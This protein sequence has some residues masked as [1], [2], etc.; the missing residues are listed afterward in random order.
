MQRTKYSFLKRKLQK[1]ELRF[2]MRIQA[3]NFWIVTIY[4]VYEEGDMG[5][6]YGFIFRYHGIAY[7]GMNTDYTGQGFDQIEYCINLLKTDPFSRRILMTSFN[8]SQAQQGVL[9]PCHSIV[10]QFYVE[11]GHRLSCTMYQRSADI[12]C[13]TPFNVAS[14]SLLVYMFCEVINNDSKYTGQKFTPGRL[15]MNHGDIHIYEDHYSELIRQVLRE[16][17]KFPQLTFKRKVN[18][19]T[20]FKYEDLELVGYQCYPSIKLKMIA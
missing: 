13:G 12:G 10:I 15:I 2:G 3:E 19:L 7:R 18:E 4:H 14:S 16:P 6:M 5:P 20:D 9:Y 11:K 8:P 1:K 17:Y